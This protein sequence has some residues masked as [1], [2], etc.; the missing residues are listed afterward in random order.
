M[1]S[2]TLRGDPSTIGNAFDTAQRAMMK[3]VYSSI[4]A[5]H[6]AGL[7]PWPFAALKNTHAIGSA[8]LAVSFA[9]NPHHHTFR[10]AIAELDAEIYPMI[11]ELRAVREGDDQQQHDNGENA[12]DD[13]ESQRRHNNLTKLFMHDPSFSDQ[14]LRDLMLNMV[15]AGRD[16]TSNALSWLTALLT[17]HPEQQRLLCEE[18][19]AAAVRVR[20]KQAEEGLA[21][22]NETEGGPVVPTLADLSS[23]ELPYL[24]GCVYEA[25][26]LFPPVPF[27]SKVVVEDCDVPF[28]LGGRFLAGTRISFCAYAM[29][30][31]PERWP[32]P[33]AFKPERWIPFKTPSAFEFPVFQGGPRSCLGQNMA[34]FEMKMLM[35]VLMQNRFFELKEGEAEHLTPSLQLTIAVCNSKQ[36]M[37]TGED[38]HNLWVHP[39]RRSSN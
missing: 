11:K 4:P 15:I 9:R 3:L 33:L 30:R 36:K 6:I 1:D 38:T 39:R 24:N 17:Q 23:D 27:D 21:V 8:G 19:D 34:L 5:F 31:D 13:S 32:A 10:A 12:G 20:A 7:A 26:R 35:F 14:E 28:G 25:L 18:I 16:T 37:G 2:A 29:G 22:V